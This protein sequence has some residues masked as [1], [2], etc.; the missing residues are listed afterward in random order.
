MKPQ[1]F[2]AVIKAGKVVGVRQTNARTQGAKT[3]AAHAVVK[4]LK[5]K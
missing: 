1:R 3:A 2:K 4:K 5:G